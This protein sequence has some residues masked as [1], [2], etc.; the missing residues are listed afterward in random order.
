MLEEVERAFVARMHSTL[1][2]GKAAS[3]ASLQG[4]TACPIR[5]AVDTERRRLGHFTPRAVLSHALGGRHE[6]DQHGFPTTAEG[7]AQLASYFGI[8]T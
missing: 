6:Q 4:L 3:L 2:Q 7:W 5:R 1:L 8:L